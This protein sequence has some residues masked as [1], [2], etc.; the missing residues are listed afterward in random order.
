MVLHHGAFD[1]SSEALSSCKTTSDRGSIVTRNFC[2]ECGSHIFSQISDVP[3]IITVKAATLDDV[4]D[5]VPQYLVWV[6]SAP[7]SCAFPQGV[8][9]FPESA[10]LEMVLALR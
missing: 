8:P 2:R 1:C 6:R 4:S 3:E 5:F 9:S 10:P 7:P